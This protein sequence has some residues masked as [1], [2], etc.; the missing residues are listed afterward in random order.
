MGYVSHLCQVVCVYLLAVVDSVVA[1]AAIYYSM[2]VFKFDV[3]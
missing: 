1:G 3:Q 2:L